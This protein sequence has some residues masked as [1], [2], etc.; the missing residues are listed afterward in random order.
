MNTLI[1]DTNTNLISLF[2]GGVSK[3]AALPSSWIRTVLG[4]AVEYGNT[5]KAEPSEIADGDWVLELEDIERDT[6]KLLARITFAERKSKSTKNRFSTG[7]VLYGKLRPYL[8]KVLSADRDG[9]CTTEIVPIKPNRAVN[10]RYL[11]HW[12]RHP[13]FLEYVTNVSHGL[14]MPRLGTDAGRNAPFILAPAAEQ[15][16]IA[17][18]LDAVLAKVG[19]CR[20]RLDR[21][22]QILKRFR[23]A[24]LQAAVSGRLTEE[25][26]GSS[27]ISRSGGE[28]VAAIAARRRALGL[29]SADRIVNDESIEIPDGELPENWIWA[30]IGQI[31]DVRLGGTPSR[32]VE[33]YWSGDISWVSSGEV[34]NCRIAST[35]ER[36]SRKGV[37]DSAAKIYPAGTVLIAMIGEGKTRGQSAI[38]DI[39]AATNQNVAGLVFDGGEVSAE[40][41][42]CWALS[43]YERTRSVGRGGNQPALNGAKVRALPIPVPSVEEQAEIARRVKELFSLADTLARQSETAASIV[44]KLTQSILAKAFRGELVSQDPKDEPAD[45]L[46]ERL[47]AARQLSGSKAKNRGHSSSRR[48]RK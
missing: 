11:Y 13:E 45:T 24:V 22:P 38:L 8:N 26:R 5:I 12:L 31:A 36:I 18:K 37:E 21:V 42:W 48:S 19:A 25:W 43:E 23:E 30:R 32:A 2:G 14:N 35:R 9:V 16:R 7:D 44:A 27:S 17:D 39:D 46:L 1:H 15:Q 47:R 28:I 6:S 4:E 10:G 41:V 20:D 40:Y 34:A 29:R 3:A 33:K